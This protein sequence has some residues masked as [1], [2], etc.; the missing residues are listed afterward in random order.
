MKKRRRGAT[1]TT[2]KPPSTR[3]HV[4]GVAR[5]PSQ[6]STQRYHT[7]ARITSQPSFTY[8]YTTLPIVTTRPTKPTTAAVATVHA[9]KTAVFFTRAYPELRGVLLQLVESPRAESVRAHHRHLPALALPV[10]G[11]LGDRGRL[12]GALLGSGS[13][14]K[15][16]FSNRRRPARPDKHEENDPEIATPPPARARARVRAPARPE[17]NAMGP[18]EGTGRED[19]HDIHTTHDIT[20]GQ[21]RGSLE[22]LRI[23]SPTGHRKTQER[24]RER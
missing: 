21:H 24:P 15:S 11:E 9:Q 4:D 8:V 3:A 1:S 22:R 5:H 14:W 13:R 2:N 6:Q 19:S 18:R 10:V 17:K 23:H 20:I 7:P 12:A 16:P